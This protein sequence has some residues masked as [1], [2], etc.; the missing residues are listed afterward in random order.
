[1]RHFYGNV[2]DRVPVLDEGLLCPID[3]AAG[4]ARIAPRSAQKKRTNFRYTRLAVIASAL[5]LSAPANAADKE[6][7]I[8]GLRL[9]MTMDEAQEATR[10]Y[11]PDLKFQPPVKEILQ[12]R[13]A[14]QTQKTAP[15]VS[16]VF[17]V[18]G[19]KEDTYIYFPY[20]PS[21]PLMIAIT[22]FH[23]NSDPPIPRGNYYE[24]LTEKCELRQDQT[25]VIAIMQTSSA[26]LLG[27][28][29]A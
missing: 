11:N 10:K 22:R 15:F 20:S 13:V 5:V 2:R 1:M 24:A 14:N 19:K 17:A 23:E 25:S 12:Y 16:H 27:R 7:D 6:A 21:E 18:S 28:K 9:G 29:K 8:V 4:T 26:H 3:S